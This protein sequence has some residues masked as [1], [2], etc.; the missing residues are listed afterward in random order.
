M[1]KANFCCQSTQS[2]RVAAVGAGRAG[3]AGGAMTPP[4][5]GRSVNPISTRS[6]RLQLAPP[7]FQ[8]FLRPCQAQTVGA[9]QQQSYIDDLAEAC[10]QPS[11]HPKLAYTGC[12]ELTHPP[13][14]HI[15]KVF[16]PCTQSSTLFEIQ[17]TKSFQLSLRL[18]YTSSPLGSRFGTHCLTILLQQHHH[19]VEV[20]VRTVFFRFKNV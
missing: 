12:F 20:V 10:K 17:H 2:R 4:D 7:D 16:L 11:K 9:V 8:T 14:H 19:I 1:E 5:F 3:G 6:S 15:Q 18:R 13:T